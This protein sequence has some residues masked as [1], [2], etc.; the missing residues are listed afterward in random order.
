M[1]KPVIFVI[2]V[3]IALTILLIIQN[4]SII[5][6]YRRENNIDRLVLSVYML[7]GLIKYRFDAPF[8]Q[9]GH[10][11]FKIRSLK[12][13]ERQKRAGKQKRFY[14]YLEVFKKLKEGYKTSKHIF[15]YI[16]RKIKIIEMDINIDIGADN[17]SQTGIITGMIWAVIG[18]LNSILID[19]SRKCKKKI[20]VT[21][22]FMEK[23]FKMTVYCIFKVRIVHII[24]VG[25]KLLK[26]FIKIRTGGDRNVPT[27]NRRF[28]EDSNGKY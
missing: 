27:P 19:N 17:A 4:V 22:D 11:G 28:N 5:L 3:N 20:I 1:L 23:R 9:F 16:A 18:I 12:K 25:L 21:P 13:R 24:V 2:L 26:Q 15:G 10:S 6:D 8:I 7:R 14:S